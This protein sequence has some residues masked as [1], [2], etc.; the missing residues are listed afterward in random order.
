MYFNGVITFND[1]ASPILRYVCDNNVQSLTQ[2]WTH[3]NSIPDVVIEYLAPKSGHQNNVHPQFHLCNVTDVTLRRT[4]PRPRE[5][6]TSSIFYDVIVNAWS[7]LKRRRSWR[8]VLAEAPKRAERAETDRWVGVL[9]NAASAVLTAPTATH[10][11]TAVLCTAR[12]IC[13][14]ANEQYGIYS[15][16]LVSCMVFLY[17]SEVLY[18]ERLFYFSLFHLFVMFRTVQ[19][20]WVKSLAAGIDGVD[21]SGSLSQPVIWF[22]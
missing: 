21:F 3:N 8:T 9:S 11:R 20:E 13:T 2:A 19:L 10:V 1:L 17:V 5:F 15:K 16:E 7:L 14:H 4:K 18:F 22:F 6:T 12:V